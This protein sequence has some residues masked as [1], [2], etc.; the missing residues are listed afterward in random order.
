MCTYKD[1]LKLALAPD[2]ANLSLENY[3]G[4]FMKEGCGRGRR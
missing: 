1:K 4:D 3:L 2:S